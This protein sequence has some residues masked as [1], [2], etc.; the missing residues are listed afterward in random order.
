MEHINSSRKRGFDKLFAELVGALEEERE[1]RSTTSI[2]ISLIEVKDRLHSLRSELATA[3]KQLSA[4]TSQRTGEVTR[5]GS[6][7]EPTRHSPDSS[8]RPADKQSQLISKL[9]QLRA[10][11]SLRS[12]SRRP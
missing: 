6:R 12:S 5:P 9:H 2:P 4:P 10:Q 7:L 1:L 3:R 8:R 11:A